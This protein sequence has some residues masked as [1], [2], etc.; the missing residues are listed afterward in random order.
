MS[1]PAPIRRLFGEV[2]SGPRDLAVLEEILADDYL[3]H[4]SPPGLPNDRT[5]VR[6]KLEA[7][8]AA[9]PDVIF[10]LEDG[11]AEGDLTAARW[12]W[13]GT[14][15]GEFAGIAPTGRRLSVRGMDFYRVRDGRIAEHWDVL[16]AMVP[17]EQWKNPNGK[18]GF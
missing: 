11:V 17:Q 13:E 4:T 1:A 2:L 3:D 6:P 5:G 8:R 10:V 18:F 16:E 7:F 15:Q 9:F 12:H 14:H